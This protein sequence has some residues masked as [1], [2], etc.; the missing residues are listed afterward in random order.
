MRTISIENLRDN[1]LYYAFRPIDDNATKDLIDTHNS[2]YLYVNI[3]EIYSYASFRACIP[4]YY[5]S[6]YIKKLADISLEESST[7]TVIYKN[8]L[9]IIVTPI[10]KK[11]NGP[12][13]F[14][15]F[16]HC[17]IKKPVNHLFINNTN[18]LCKAEIKEEIYYGL[19]GLIFDKNLRPLMYCYVDSIINISK[20][21]LI[22]DMVC[23]ID[24]TVLNKDTIMSKFIMKE[25]IPEF[26]KISKSTIRRFIGEDFVRDISIKVE[27]GDLSKF[28]YKPQEPETEDIN[29]AITNFLKTFPI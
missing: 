13:N 24:P 5:L 28:F 16:S 2:N 18:K 20:E 15:K 1:L 29:L 11:D 25:F 6:Y 26:L 14:L 4:I 9:D 17:N 21:V 7:E 10:A 12:F 19:P 22:K 23:A 8:P 27:I 3:S